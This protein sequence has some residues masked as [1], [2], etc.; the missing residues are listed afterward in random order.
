MDI[1]K[2]FSENQT[3]LLL[4]PS[5]KY[6]KAIVEVATKL[7]GKRIVYITVNKTYDVLLRKFKKDGANADN[8]FFIDA[9][10]KSFEEVK[11]SDTV[12]FV[13]SPSALTDLSLAVTDALKQNVDYIIFDAI[14]NFLMY[15]DQKTVGIFLS[16]L[17]DE[18]E[19]TDVKAVFYALDIQKEE[20][21]IDEV[22][23]FVDKVI[24][25]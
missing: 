25:Y 16:R 17:I 15:N 2:E 21:L 7:S 12:F 13:N 4:M 6:N 5:E 18:I 11:N 24:K 8:F 20:E 3:I 23:S 10:S 9:I 19:E 1:L 14:S 22:E